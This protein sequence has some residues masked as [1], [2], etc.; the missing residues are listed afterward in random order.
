[1][2]KG[3][4]RHWLP[5]LTVWQ[6]RSSIWIWNWRT[7]RPIGQKLPVGKPQGRVII[8]FVWQKYRHA[9]RL[10][11][12][13]GISLKCMGPVS[14][15]SNSAGR[16][17]QRKISKF[18]LPPPPHNPHIV[19]DTYTNQFVILNFPCQNEW[20]LQSLCLKQFF[21][22]LPVVDWDVFPPFTTTLT[23][24]ADWCINPIKER[25]WSV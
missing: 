16:K 22:T 20:F 25:K 17:W 8:I 9:W 13:L 5:K 18:T 6:L 14:N 21:C 23:D 7:K 24:V 19:L 2:Q 12:D 4:C 15:A 3:A 10:P 1:M 11:F